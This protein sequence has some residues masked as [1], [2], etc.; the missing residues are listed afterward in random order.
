MN[1][2][3]SKG[4]SIMIDVSGPEDSDIINR[5]LE[6]IKTLA[7]VDEASVSSGIPKPEASATAVF[8]RNQVHVLLKGLL[9]FEEERKRLGKEIKKIEKEISASDK[10]LT[11]KN[12]LEK[13]PADIVAKVKEKVE[14]LSLKRDKLNQNLSFFENIDD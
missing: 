12:F 14:A 13:A 3:P 9:D 1:I 4:V 11:N 7:K 8:G 5:N 10:K 6:H 2:P